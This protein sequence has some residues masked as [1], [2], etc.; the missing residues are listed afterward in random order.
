MIWPLHSTKIELLLFQ[1]W[2]SAVNGWCDE[3]DDDSGAV[4]AKFA[5]RVMPFHGTKVAC[6]QSCFWLND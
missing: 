4:L 2:F 3:V 5:S 6:C 1:L